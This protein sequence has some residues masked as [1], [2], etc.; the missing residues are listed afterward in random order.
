M[1]AFLESDEAPWWAVQWEQLTI[2]KVATPV[3]RRLLGRTI[4]GIA[5]ER[6]S[7]P[8]TAALDLVAEHGHFWVSPPNKRREDL[9]ILLAHEA[10]IPESDSMTLDPERHAELGVQERSINT[11]PRFLADFVYGR[12]VIGIGEAVRKTSAEGA[13]RLG[14]TGRGTLETGAA[15]DLVVFDPDRL[16]SRAEATGTS[17]SGI[18]HVMVNGTWVVS[19][20]SLTRSRPGVAL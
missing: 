4:G 19:D 17:V 5:E 15:A 16:A 6:G 1:I 3:G 9:E 11:F 12:G 7:S 10:C 8:A 20:G 18:R 13:R 2:S 14:L